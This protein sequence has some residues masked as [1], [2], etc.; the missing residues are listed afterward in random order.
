[1]QFAGRVPRPCRQYALKIRTFCVGHEPLVGGKIQVLGLK[2]FAIVKRG[3]RHTFR[4][5]YIEQ[6][7]RK[8]VT[9]AR[10]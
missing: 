2:S 5:K 10:G 9:T 8:L 4:R 3:L 1:M 6:E 7:R